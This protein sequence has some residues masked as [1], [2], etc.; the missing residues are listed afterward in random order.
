MQIINITLILEVK[1]ANIYNVAKKLVFL[2]GSLKKVRY[3]K[4]D[5]DMVLFLTNNQVVIKFNNN[6]IFIFD[7]S[8]YIGLF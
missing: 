3:K 2:V 7:N 5:I 6:F 4:S 1:Y 8:K